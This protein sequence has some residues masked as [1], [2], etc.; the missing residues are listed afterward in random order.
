MRNAEIGYAEAYFKGK[1]HIA[2]QY[3]LH[4][5]KNNC[6]FYTAIEL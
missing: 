2:Y 1:T 4:A 3:F 5:I 6:R